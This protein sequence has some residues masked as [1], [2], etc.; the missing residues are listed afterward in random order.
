M[1]LCAFRLLCFICNRRGRCFESYVQVSRLKWAK[2]RRSNTF[3]WRS[4]NYNRW[5]VSRLRNPVSRNV[6]WTRR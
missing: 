1:F 2:Y 3:N 6:R 4:N 5:A